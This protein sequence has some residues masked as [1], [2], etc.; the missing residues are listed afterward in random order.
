MLSDSVSDPIYYCSLSSAAD[1]IRAGQISPVELTEKLLSRIDSVDGQLM[2]YAT[3]MTEQAME[4][5]RKAE[6]E[7]QAGNYKGPLHGMPIAVK[8]LC[9]TAGTRTMGGLKVLRHFVPD[10]DATVVHKPVSYTH[11]T[12]P[13]NREV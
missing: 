13:T 1:A 7:I 4:A 8:D 11:L 2:S 10:Y 9:F 12:L 6:Q 3:V 5:A